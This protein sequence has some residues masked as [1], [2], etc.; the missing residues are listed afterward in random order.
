MKIFKIKLQIFLTGFIIYQA[1]LLMHKQDQGYT[2]PGLKPAQVEKQTNGFV[3]PAYASDNG[4]MALNI[5]YSPYTENNVGNNDH[6]QNAAKMEAMRMM[7]SGDMA[8]MERAIQGDPMAA[9][10]FGYR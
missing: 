7:Q 3:S 4:S 9:Q 8:E 5:P 6:M 1:G 2:I 10:M